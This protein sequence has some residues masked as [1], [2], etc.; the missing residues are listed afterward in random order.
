MHFIRRILPPFFAFLK[1]SPGFHLLTYDTCIPDAERLGQAANGS[2]VV[3]APAGLVRP[4]GK[5]RALLGNGIHLS[6]R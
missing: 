2:C 3:V 4:F 6:Y 1:P 5:G